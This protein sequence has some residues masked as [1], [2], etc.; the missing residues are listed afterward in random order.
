MSTATL[1]PSEHVLGHLTPRQRETVMQLVTPAT[2]DEIAD[3]LGMPT[4]RSVEHLWVSIRDRLWLFL[5][6]REGPG[7]TGTGAALRVAL[8]RIL[9]GIDPCPCGRGDRS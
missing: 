4:R 2:M 1:A 9:Y 7:N 3:R 8:V 6:E 5:P